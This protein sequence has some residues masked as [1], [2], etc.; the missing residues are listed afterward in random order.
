MFVTVR[1]KIIL[2]LVFIKIPRALSSRA[3]VPVLLL[4]TLVIVILV[5][6]ALVVLIV[7]LLQLSVLLSITEGYVNSLLQD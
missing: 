3:V 2:R 7:V 6:P 4:S 1:N 5:V